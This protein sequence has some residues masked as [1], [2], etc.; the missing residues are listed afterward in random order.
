[1]Y[2]TTYNIPCPNCR[3]TIN[4]EVSMPDNQ[5]PSSLGQ[6]RPLI[7]KSV[8][9]KNIRDW[10]SPEARYRI[11]LT[12][13]WG[14]IKREFCGA[15]VA[16]GVCPIECERCRGEIVDL[17]RLEKAGNPEALLTWLAKDHSARWIEKLIAE[18]KR[19]E[20][21]PA[22]ESPQ[23]AYDG[24]F[25]KREPGNLFLEMMKDYETDE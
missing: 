12:T 4:K 10:V 23:Q 16:R 3:N 17:F 2:T 5:P 11:D 24:L 21:L 22:Q 7:V 18:E 15:V 9:V 6:T 1:M 25:P 19:R 14:I 8:D 13:A 20:N